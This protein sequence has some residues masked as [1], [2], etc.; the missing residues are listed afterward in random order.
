MTRPA[1][2]TSRGFTLLEVLVAIAVFAVF[3]ALAYGSLSRLLDSRERIEAERAFWRELALAFAQIEDDLGAARPRTVRDIY[4]NPQP[5][6]RGQPTDSRV[7]GEPALTFTRGGLFVLGEG[8]RPDLARVGYRLREGALQRL[9]WPALDQ[10]TRSEPQIAALLE[11]VTELRVRFYV[12]AGG[13]VDAWPPVGQLTALP[14]AVE[15]DLTLEGRGSFQ[16]I[17]PVGG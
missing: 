5:A 16:R 8:A 14:A 10:P 6:F 1:A 2:S 3:S 7:L 17:L 15:V 13:W 11:N 4:G 9:T 12:P